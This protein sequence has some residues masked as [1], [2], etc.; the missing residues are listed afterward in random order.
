MCHLF[1]YKFKVHKNEKNNVRL[2][3]YVHWSEGKVDI[4][5]NTFELFRSRSDD[6]YYN[7]KLTHYVGQTVRKYIHDIVISINYNRKYL[8][9]A[10]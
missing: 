10:I 2:S 9:I 4:E 7:H 8:T 1:K 3:Q 5:R 6:V